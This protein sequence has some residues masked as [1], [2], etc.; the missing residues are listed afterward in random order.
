MNFGSILLDFV[1]IS[2]VGTMETYF[3]LESTLIF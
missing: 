1:D 2:A 3:Y